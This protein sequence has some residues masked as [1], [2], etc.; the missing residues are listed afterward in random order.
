MKK[1]KKYL[2]TIILLIICILPASTVIANG[3]PPPNSLSV[4]ISKYSSEC[5][6]ADILIKL[7]DND[8]NYVAF[9]S[10][11]GEDLDISPSSE[12]VQ[13][14]EDGFMSYT[15]HFNGA[16][17]ES[18]MNEDGFINRNI[19][20]EHTSKNIFAYSDSGPAYNDFISDHYQLKIV[21]LDINGSILQTSNEVSVKAGITS[22]FVGRIIYDAEQN[23]AKAEMRTNM[24]AI[25]FWLPLLIAF[26]IFVSTG[27]EILAAIPF[28]IKPKRKIFVVN[29]IT[30]FILTI[31]ILAGLIKPYWLAVL[32]MEVFV[33]SSEYFAYTKLFKDISN[34]KLLIYTVVANTTSLLIGLLLNMLGI[35]TV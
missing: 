31:V 23:I 21:L 14:N 17:S 5:S 9:N 13:Y 10:N 26:R 29:L 2:F 18:K 3:P 30:Q 6:Y 7:S 11:Y 35:F 25:M 28:K 20:D 24:L 33:Y 8:S 15:F 34:K 16:I 19:T 22:Y 4:H 27:L 1:G 32:I 12:I